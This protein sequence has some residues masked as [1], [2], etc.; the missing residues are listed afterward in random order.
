MATETGH[1]VSKESLLFGL[2]NINIA[3]KAIIKPGAVIR[4]DLA[5]MKIG[6][7][8]VI[9]DNTVLRPPLKKSRV[10]QTYFPVQIGDYVWIGRDCV[11]SATMIGSFVEIGDGSIIGKRCVLRDHCRILPG[12]VL[13]P[14]TIIPPFA[15]YGG[16][17]ARCIGEVNEAIAFYQK[18]RMH[19]YYE[20]F[21]PEKSKKEKREKKEK[22]E[23]KSKRSAA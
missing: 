8:I 3:G 17:P 2:Y 11:V 22:K 5:I 15:V 14:D 21:L 13:P 19:T 7:N 18:D 9:Q 6:K 1:R 12:T 4:G 23:K 10:G 16:F 20:N